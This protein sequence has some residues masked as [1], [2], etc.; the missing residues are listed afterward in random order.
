[1]TKRE[2]L[3]QQ[4]TSKKEKIHSILMEIYEL[5]KQSLLLCDKDQWFTEKL[6]THGRG[7]KKEQKL[8][9]RIHWN[10]DFLDESTNKAITIERSH[11]V[12]ING[13]WCGYD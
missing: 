1:M 4:I 7:Q 3:Q 2:K 9:G 12:R 10:E 6:E 13:K 11:I 5:E 8:Y